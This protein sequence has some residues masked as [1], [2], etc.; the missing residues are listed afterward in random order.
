MEPENYGNWEY[1]APTRKHAQA[2]AIMCARLARVAVTDVYYYQRDL[3]YWVAAA[4]NEN[5]RYELT[6]CADGN[7]R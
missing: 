6:L 3:G 4:Y 2:M 7:W 5:Y 1:Q